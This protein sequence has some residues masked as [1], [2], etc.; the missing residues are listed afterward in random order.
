MTSNKMH[1]FIAADDEANVFG[2]GTTRGECEA[3]ARDYRD[4]DIKGLTF[5]QATTDALDAVARDGADARRVLVFGPGNRC[6]HESESG[7]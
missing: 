7:E 1:G 6:W 4:D 2:S 3:S 5:Y